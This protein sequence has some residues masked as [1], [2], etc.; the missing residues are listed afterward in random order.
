M[1]AQ[2]RPQNYSLDLMLAVLRTA[3]CIERKFKYGISETSPSVNL[4][5]SHSIKYHNSEHRNILYEELI[6]CADFLSCFLANLLYYLLY[7]LK[8]RFTCFSKIP[9]GLVYYIKTY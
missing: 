3:Y 2:T 9:R 7:L 4:Y 1:S 6:I 8:K 5:Q